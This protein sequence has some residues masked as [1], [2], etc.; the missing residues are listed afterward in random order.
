MT[1]RKGNNQG[2]KNRK[3]KNSNTKSTEEK[4]QKKIKL[5]SGDVLSASS[6]K[7]EGSAATAMD[8]VAKQHAPKPVLPH[9]PGSK[10]LI[11]SAKRTP[12]TRKKGV[13]DQKKW[14]IQNRIKIYPSELNKTQGDHVTAFGLFARVVKRQVEEI[15]FSD[16]SESINKIFS[17]IHSFNPEKSAEISER[18][19]EIINDSENFVSNTTFSK[20]WKI[21][22]EFIPDEKQK[23]LLMGQLVAG[24]RL[25]YQHLFDVLTEEY[26][27][28][29]NKL[30]NITFYK[31]PWKGVSDAAEGNKVRWALDA[32]DKLALKGES[33]ITTDI[34]EVIK[35]LKTLYWFPPVTTN[36]LAGDDDNEE[37]LHHRDSENNLETLKETLSRHINIF[38]YAY[39]EF[40]FQKDAI[41]ENFITEIFDYG[42]NNKL[43]NWAGVLLLKNKDKDQFITETIDY[44][45]N[46]L[47]EDH[48]Q[49][50]T[51]TTTAAERVG[52][53]IDPLKKILDFSNKKEDKGHQR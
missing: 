43:E 29:M 1:R 17:I 13:A 25:S 11:E 5:K 21:I 40:L 4:D 34:D 2:S 45:N 37:S 31:I 48:K 35:N 53:A 3:R 6:I 24:L 52:T 12:P 9:T 49:E 26:L 28:I 33:G 42:F 44:V 30:P 32:L 41:I 19:N 51:T 15:I 23:A 36:N 46:N 7:Q 10:N 22:E 14:N 50:L 8:V 18:V 47:V 39:P 27:R 20:S 38:F 16:P